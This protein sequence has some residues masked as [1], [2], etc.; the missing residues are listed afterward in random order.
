MIKL[1]QFASLQSSKSIAQFGK[2]KR[3]SNLHCEKIEKLPFQKQLSI[4]MNGQSKA[5]MSFISA[6][7][8][9]RSNM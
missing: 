8:E 1:W 9:W 2:C 5:A 4:A 6:Y 7:K 3:G